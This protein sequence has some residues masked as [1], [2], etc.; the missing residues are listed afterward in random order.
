MA[1]L[2]ALTF[3]EKA[4]ERPEPDLLSAHQGVKNAVKALTA[5]RAQVKTQAER[6]APTST[7]QAQAMKA[8]YNITFVRHKGVVKYSETSVM[9]AVDT[10]CEKKYHDPNQTTEAP[11]RQIGNH[12]HEPVG[13]SEL[14]SPQRP[15]PHQPEASKTH[16]HFC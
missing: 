5:K 1:L 13:R 2:D 7:K 8:T 12:T 16:L 9:E 3:F 4:G 10:H 15:P 11:P 14:S 6:E